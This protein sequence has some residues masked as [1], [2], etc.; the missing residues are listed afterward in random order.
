MCS[1]QLKI[2]ELREND[3]ALRLKMM[4]ALFK[5]GELLRIPQQH[6]SC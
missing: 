5:V 2:R 6:R 3:K 1:L 4:N